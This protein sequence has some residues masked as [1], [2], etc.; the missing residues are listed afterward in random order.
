M[1]WERWRIGGDAAFDFE[2][3]CSEATAAA[4]AGELVC[5][6]RSEL[7]AGASRRWREGSRG[8]GRRDPVTVWL[9][10]GEDGRLWPARLEASSRFGTITARLVAP[11][12]PPD[13]Q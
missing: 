9:R 13:A 4:A 2:L 6:I 8:D 12:R 3:A 7:L 5:S 1:Q 10:R 11:Q